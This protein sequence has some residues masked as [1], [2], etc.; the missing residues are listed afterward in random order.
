[1][2]QKYWPDFIK[3][4]AET[5]APKF[6]TIDSWKIKE[7]GKILTCGAFGKGFVWNECES[8][9]LVLAVPFSCK[10]RLCMSCYRKRLF[11]WSLQLSKII[12]PSLPH[13]HV[14]FTMPGRLADLLF[15]RLIKPRF[16]NALAAKVYANRQRLTTKVDDSYKP[17]ILSTVHIAGNSLNFNPHVH[18][19]ATRDLLN[20]DTGEL[21]EV[22]FLPYQTLRYDWQRTICR[23]LKRKKILSKAEYGFFLKKYPRGFHVHVQSLTKRSTT[24]WAITGESN[25]VIFKTAQYVASSIFHNSQIQSVDHG[26]RELTFK[27]KSRVDSRTREKTFSALT[28]PI[29]EFMARMLFFLPERHEKS[30]RYYGL[31]VRP[32]KKAQMA[33]TAKTSLWAESIKSS[34][35]TQNPKACP[36]CQKLMSTRIIYRCHALRMERILKTKYALV[37][38]Y[39][40]LLAPKKPP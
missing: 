5:Q 22:N 38:G 6:G 27:F 21:K 37:D 2:W 12:N 9:K 29:H 16:M 31:Y 35:A 4:Y 24:D 36:L 28:M 25:D 15:S 19:I 26:R 34:F 11:G 10:S 1:M 8:C 7:A 23:Y 13:F 30:I 39:F 20:P 18:M 3:T 40:F 14:V 32:A 33:E 17:G